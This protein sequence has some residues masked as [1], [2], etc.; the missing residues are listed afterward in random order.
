METDLGSF[1]TVDMHGY[2]G[3]RLQLSARRQFGALHVRPDHVVG[4]PGRDSLGELAGVVGVQFP[5]GFF[6]IG[7]P[8][9]YRNPIKRPS[10]RIP[11]R[12]KNQSVRLWRLAVVR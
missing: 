8:N 11:N 12:S 1:V 7:P 10:V 3:T 6:L 2:L 5:S 4:L 9:L